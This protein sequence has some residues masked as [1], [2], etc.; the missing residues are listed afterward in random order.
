MRSDKQK[1]IIRMN[2]VMTYPV[3]WNRFKVADNFVQNF[4][5]ALGSEN[6]A[7]DFQYRY[8]DRTLTMTADSTFAKDWLIYIG[9]STKRDDRRKQAGGFGEG[10]KIAA[11][12]SVR[13]FDMAVTMESE[14]WVLRVTSMQGEIDGNKVD[15]LAYEVS[16]RPYRQ[17]SVLRLENVSDFFNEN[18]EDVLS[19]YYYEDNKL[20]GKCLIKTD[21]YAIYES[22][23]DPAGRRQ[24]GYVFACCQRRKT[25]RIPLIICNHYYRPWEDDRDRDDFKTRETV[26]C[27]NEVMKHLSP[28]MSL[29]ILEYFRMSWGGRVG[30][31][32]GELDWT[33]TISVLIHN[34]KNDLN[35]VKIFKERYCSSIIYK[36]LPHTELSKFR[37]K[38]ALLWF[39][40]SPL[41]SQ[42]R[43]VI[44]DF[45]FLKIKSVCQLCEEM[46]GYT[47]ERDPN[48]TEQRLIDILKRAAGDVLDDLIMVERWPECRISLNP[49]APV[50]GYTR[51][52]KKNG[53]KNPYGLK[54][55][56]E[57]D[58]IYL[59]KELFEENQFSRAF[60]VYCHELLHEYGGDTSM[61]FH[62]SLSFMNK[63]IIK[64]IE[65]FECYEKEWVCY[66]VAG[67]G[68]GK[69]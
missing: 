17:N 31:G 13:D 12:V 49:K 69:R 11:L 44:P 58:Y 22:V 47:L 24:L 64:N 36:D 37:R 45:R 38:I 59:Q 4:Y 68:G 1:E 42:Y 33:R 61:A 60:S 8:E 41:R 18:F 67:I 32:Y 10:F 3:S 9:A 20:F 2:I 56:F 15:F 29:T 43:Y 54:R 30:T 35:T 6:F 66:S 50:S 21:D 28:E 14:D 55:I 53:R 57:A 16:N 40:Q 51:V 48:I 39:Q 19:S 25:I 63:K 26:R 5:D 62:R 34:I 27:V 65:R 52:I 46:D 23:Y 7:H